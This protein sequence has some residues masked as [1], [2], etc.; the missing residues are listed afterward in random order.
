MIAATFI[1]CLTVIVVAMIVVYALRGALDTYRGGVR[2]EMA[3]VLDALPAILGATID[4]WVKALLPEP[5]VDVEPQVEG[6]RYTAEQWAELN[7]AYRAG[8]PDGLREAV[9]SM[10]DGT[11]P[12]P[13]GS[14]PRW[15]DPTSVPDDE[16]IDPIRL[17]QPL[18][19]WMPI[20][21]LD[22]R[23]LFGEPVE[24]EES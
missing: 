8:G 17:D 23:F 11:D 3:G 24:V 16:D 1:I 5:E 7:A 10:R 15:A 20:D 4:P 6:E 2:A 13:P 14:R 21:P 12:R 19:D 9:G 18:D 22:G